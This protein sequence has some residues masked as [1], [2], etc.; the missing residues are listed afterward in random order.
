M[1]SHIGYINCTCFMSSETAPAV[2]R[3][4]AWRRIDCWLEALTW[5][6]K[7]GATSLQVAGKVFRIGHLGNNDSVMQLGAIAGAEMALIDAGYKSFTPGAGVTLIQSFSTALS[8]AIAVENSRKLVE[9]FCH[10]Y[11]PYRSQC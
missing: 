2:Q 6:E 3:P 5:P 7:H 4:S 10:G 8:C 9:P 1:E 11:K